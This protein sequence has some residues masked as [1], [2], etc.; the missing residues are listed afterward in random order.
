MLNEITKNISF[1]L[2]RKLA[3]FSGVN[4]PVSRGIINIVYSSQLMQHSYLDEVCIYRTL[5]RLPSS[6]DISDC[7]DETTTGFHFQEDLTTTVNTA[8]HTNYYEAH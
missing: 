3:L 8:S 5:H 2:T 4:I 7:Y 6:Y 1:L